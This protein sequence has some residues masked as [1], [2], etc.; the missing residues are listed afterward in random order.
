MRIV[1]LPMSDYSVNHT[2][3]TPFA[4]TVRKSLTFWDPPQVGCLTIWE[5]LDAT[6]GMI[7]APSFKGCREAD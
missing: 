3:L 7:P 5:E 4:I 1:L 6:I 2:A